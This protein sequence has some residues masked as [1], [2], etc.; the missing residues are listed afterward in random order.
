MVKADDSEIYAAAYIAFGLV[1][2]AYVGLH[3]RN[4][5][6]RRRKVASIPVPACLVLLIGPLFMEAKS[7]MVERMYAGAK[8]PETALKR[9]TAGT[10]FIMAV[11]VIFVALFATLYKRAQKKH[12]AETDPASTPRV[13]W[14]E[15]VAFLFTG[16][17][18]FMGILMLE[19]GS[20]RT[21][22]FYCTTSIF[23]LAFAALL[24]ADTDEPYDGFIVRPTPPPTKG[25]TPA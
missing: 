12:E 3:W 6:T 2:I 22:V 21:N 9:N 4:G 1:I 14:L 24:L 15:W 10:A 18:A 13:T 8:F 17:G 20:Q 23:S 7:E 25:T 19:F 5:S 16:G 11:S